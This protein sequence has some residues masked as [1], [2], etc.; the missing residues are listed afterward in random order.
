MGTSNLII[1][2]SNLPYLI[3]KS[4][5]TQ[6]TF[7]YRLPPGCRG[8]DR[9]QL[10]RDQHLLAFLSSGYFYLL[11]LSYATTA[12]A[13]T[14]SPLPQVKLHLRIPHEPIKT[15]DVDQALTSL[16][17]GT[18]AG[19]V[20][21]YDLAKAL[22]N[23]RVL[24]K[25]RVEMGVEEGLV[26]T[27]LQRATMKEVS[28]YVKGEGAVEG[29]SDKSCSVEENMDKYLPSFMVREE[30]TMQ[31][32]EGMPMFTDR[33]NGS[34]AFGGTQIQQPTMQRTSLLSSVRKPAIISTLK[35]LHST[36][37]IVTVTQP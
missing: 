23:E 17:L 25:R 19:N 11:D 31:M 10:L 30:Q 22:E 33:S 16:V 7:L 12:T 5:A 29:E 26:V 6:D 9:L 18:T 15:F 34:V 36:A 28:A 35:P 21:V 24:A 1:S 3:I 27:R 2:G 37:S 8:V 13:T 32:P 20:Y 14:A 4:L